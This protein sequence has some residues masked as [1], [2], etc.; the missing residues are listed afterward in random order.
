MNVQVGKPLLKASVIVM[1]QPG[2][3]KSKLEQ[4]EHVEALVGILLL[5]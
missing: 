3:R 5:D 4:T 1:P 2:L